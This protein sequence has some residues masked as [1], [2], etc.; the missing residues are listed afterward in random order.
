MNTRKHLNI[1]DD[2]RAL[3]DYAALRDEMMKL[4]HPARP[5]V[6]WKQAETL[7]LRLFEHN[8]VE[9]QTAAWYTLARTHIAGISGLNEGMALIDA[10]LSHQWSLAWPV[11]VH[12]WLEILAGLNPRL[13][14]V[15]R[16]LPFNQ[17]DELP[18]LYAAD[19]TLISLADTLG[20][21][22]LQ[23]ASRLAPLQQ[24]IKQAI[25]RLENL[26]ENA[27]TLPAV[28]LPAQALAVGNE[29]NQPPEPAPV[30][31]LS[32]AS[33]HHGAQASHAISVQATRHIYVL[34]VP[35][36]PVDERAAPPEPSGLALRLRRAGSFLA[37]A[38]TALAVAGIVL[39]GWC[40]HMR[41]L[42]EIQQLST[43]LAP[44]PEALSPTQLA[45]LHH[46]SPTL[47]QEAEAWTQQT[48]AQL[49]RL[50]AMPPGWPL[51]Y[52]HALVAQSQT[53]WPGDV[54]TV[55]LQHD[56]QQ[57]L[58]QNVLPATALA[59][60]REGMDK[61]QR[62]TDRLNGLDEKRGKYLTV[63]ELKSEVFAIAQAFNQNPPA[64]E[65]LRQL[66]TVRAGNGASAIQLQQTELHLKQLLA[67]YALLTAPAENNSATVREAAPA[68]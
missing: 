12:A 51:L 45:A 28:V 56:W 47:A 8:G 48:R 37:G 46:D 26:P 17:R 24:Q 64:E 9:L 14:K 38:L 31:V 55:D 58:T 41:P 29:A 7:S 63:S 22:E 2:P 32:L 3:P 23:Q 5:D 11:N 25:A 19:K 33:A 4:T 54:H 43:S 30:A 49:D 50:I 65:Q 40:S 59:S 35:P 18:G 52:G 1:G 13:Q 57:Q 10:L 27:D 61:L 67:S 21:H 16:T 60:W 39:W 44:L 36:Q 53:L 68:Q 34:E 42:S 15:L 62:L 20:R 6:N 66:S